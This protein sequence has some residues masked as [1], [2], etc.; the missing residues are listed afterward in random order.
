MDL[1][2]KKKSE[3][4]GDSEDKTSN[5]TATGINSKLIAV[6]NIVKDQAEI[7]NFKCL[8]REMRLE[9]RKLCCGR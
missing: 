4:L 9:S 8:M 2:V 7:R 5:A 1:K 3:E 6:R